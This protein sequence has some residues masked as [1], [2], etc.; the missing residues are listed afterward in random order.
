[1]LKIQDSPYKYLSWL[2]NGL[3]ALLFSLLLGF[4]VS[5]LDL[6]FVA[7]F[8]AFSGAIIGSLFDWLLISACLCGKNELVHDKSLDLVNLQQNYPPLSWN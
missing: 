5:I 3:L 1:M 6:N 8:S 7:R 4:I 2:L